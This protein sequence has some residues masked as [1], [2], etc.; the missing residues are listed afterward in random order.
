M[1]KIIFGGAFDPIHLGHLNMAFQAQKMV[2]GE[3]IFVPA[4]VSVWKTDSVNQEH[5]LAMMKLAIKGYEGFSI[6]TFE[7]EQE[8][9]PRSYVT[10]DHFKNKYPH[11]KLFFLIGQDQANAFHEWAHPEE[12]AAKTQI[13]YFKRPKCEVN[14]ANIDK[15]HMLALEGP[16]IDVSSSDIRELRSALTP[17][18]V[19]A[20]IED[21][22]LYY[23]KKIKAMITEKRFNHSKEVAH[24]AYRIAKSQQLDYSKAYIA[25]IIHDIAKYYDKDE[26]LSLMKKYYPDYVNIG[27]YAYHQFLGEMVASNDFNIKDIDILNA[28]KYHTTGRKGMSTLEKLIYACDKIEPTRQY[29]STDLINAMKEDVNSGFVTV[30]QA[31]MEFLG[32]MNKTI[33]NRL[34]E[35]CVKYYLG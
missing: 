26:A 29:D 19:L 28:I 32:R 31:N 13:I 30:L 12:I 17:F 3:V 8:S 7:L 35:E 4:K 6:D 10:V 1:N 33:D 16:E 11:D 21:N 2:G 18:D 22:D 14:Q 24:L 25:G 34:T 9:Q 15:F 23:I 5:K 27:A 20:Y